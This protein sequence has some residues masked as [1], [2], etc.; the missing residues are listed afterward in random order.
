M[1]PAPTKLCYPQGPCRCILEF[2]RARRPPVSLARSR[3][4]CSGKTRRPWTSPRSRSRRRDRGHYSD[5]C[6]IRITP[7]TN[8]TNMSKRNIVQ[9]KYFSWTCVERRA[10]DLGSNGFIHGSQLVLSIH[11]VNHSTPVILVDSC[12][13]SSHSGAFRRNTL[14]HYRSSQ[15]L[16]PRV[17][18]WRTSLAGPD[19]PG[20]GSSQSSTG[21]PLN[22]RQNKHAVHIVT[23]LT[24]DQDVQMSQVHAPQDTPLEA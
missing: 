9:E 24:V 14:C 2:C 4:R 7:V 15:Q 21:T 19:A 3:L 18:I 17:R 12:R 20:R 22:A 23:S 6:C 8:R 10:A 13:L 16:G 11:H 5:F 1:V